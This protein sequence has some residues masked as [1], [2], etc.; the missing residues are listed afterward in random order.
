MNAYKLADFLDD[1]N[2]DHLEVSTKGVSTMLRQQAD[3]IAELEKEVV[4]YRT[5]AEKLT[6]RLIDA[7]VTPQTS[8]EP[9]AWYS[10]RR[11]YF[12]TAKPTDDNSKDAIPLYTTPH[13]ASDVKQAKPRLSDEEINNI[14]DK[15]FGTVEYELWQQIIKFARAIENR[16]MK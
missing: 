1:N 13:H 9:V 3:R 15:C 10:Q 2:N 8:A 14:A 11:Q 5:D 4:M 16:R 12:W 7:V 6:M